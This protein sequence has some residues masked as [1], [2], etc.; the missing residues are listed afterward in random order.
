MRITKKLAAL[1]LLSLVAPV[2]GAHALGA[3]GEGLV[4]GLLHLLYGSHHPFILIGFGLW[5][6]WRVLRRGSDG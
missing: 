6:M 5:V 3:E 4:D 2:V 1:A